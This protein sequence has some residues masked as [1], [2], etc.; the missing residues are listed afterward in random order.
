MLNDNDL[1]QQIG[2]LHAQR[3]HLPREER[4]D[5]APLSW[6]IGEDVLYTIAVNRETALMFLGHDEVIDI[7]SEHP[8]HDGI[9]VQ[10]KKNGAVIEELQTS[11]YFGSILL[12][13]PKIINL[14]GHKRGHLV[15]PPASFINN[16]YVISD[17]FLNN[18][19]PWDEYALHDGDSCLAEL[20][21]C[22][23]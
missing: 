9:T 19:E 3:Q 2:I 10:F 7:S 21:Q 17:E 23:L 1:S 14:L 8:E 5:G 4:G 15:T 13:N 16:E 22:S 20:C 11:E 6:V 12:S 18:R